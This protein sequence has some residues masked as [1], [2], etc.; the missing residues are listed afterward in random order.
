MV[1]LSTNQSLR[2]ELIKKGFENVK[3]FSWDESAQK[4]ADLMNFEKMNNID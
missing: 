4:I 2:Q 3:R 1:E